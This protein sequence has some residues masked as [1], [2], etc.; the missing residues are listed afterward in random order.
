LIA[1]GWLFAAAWKSIRRSEHQT[2]LTA[3]MLEKGLKSE[4][5]ERLLN[6]GAEFVAS[7]PGC[8]KPGES[9]PEVRIVNAMSAQSYDGDDIQ[10]VL[11]AARV[12]GVI[13]ESAVAM[14]KTLSDN[15]AGAE[16]IAKVLRNRSIR[17]AGD[18]SPAAGRPA[19]A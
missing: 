19:T 3:L 16:D 10:T 1:L 13:D 7:E 14:V 2:R 17:P 12:N 9:D 4:E 11:A 8:T 15:W 5:I 6:A 18:A